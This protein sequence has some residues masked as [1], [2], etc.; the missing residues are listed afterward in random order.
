MR[1]LGRQVGGSVFG[2]AR[3]GEIEEEGAGGGRARELLLRLVVEWTCAVITLK[4][5][6]ENKLNAFGNRI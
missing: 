3:A 4:I 1:V 5:Y 6:D 2:V